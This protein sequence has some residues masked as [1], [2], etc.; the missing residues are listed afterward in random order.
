MGKAFSLVYTIPV[1]SQRDMEAMPNSVESRSRRDDVFEDVE[2]IVQ[3]KISVLQQVFHHQKM[4]LIA[5]HSFYVCA[6]MQQCPE[7]D[8]RDAE[9]YVNESTDMM[10]ESSHEEVGETIETIKKWGEYVKMKYLEWEKSPLQS[11]SNDSQISQTL[12]G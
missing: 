12:E 2:K 1:F 11:P 5:N 8:N 7:W 3:R 4:K 6:S 10:I 9:E